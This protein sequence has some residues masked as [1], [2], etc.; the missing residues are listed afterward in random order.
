MTVASLPRRG[1]SALIG[2]TAVVTGV[3]V[4]VPPTSMTSTAAGAP[5]ARLAAAACHRAAPS[6]PVTATP[7]PG[8]P[9]DWVV[10]SFDGT[11]IRAHW[12]PVDLP[13]GQPAPTVLMGPGWGS[14]G[15]TDTS[16]SS[17]QGLLGAMS[18]ATL[19]GA[20]FNVLT[21]DP[22]GFG[23]SGGLAE[24]DSP[25]YEARDVSA[26]IDWAATLPGVEL[27]APGDPRLG[28]VGGSYGG[29]IQFVTAATDCRV[30][31]IVP[32]IA[33]HSLV[34]SLGKS[35]LYKAGWA[36]LLY[37]AATS[38]H[39]DPEI[40]DARAVADV[41]GA[42][43]AAARDWF[44]A[45]GP[46]ALIAR[47]RVPTLIVQGTVDTLFTLQEG[48]TNEQILER[49]HV[50]TAMVWFCGGHGL[51]L[52][53]HGDLSQTTAATLAWLDRYLKGDRAVDTGPGFR[54]VDQNGT[55]HSAPAYPPRAGRPLT[56]D[57]GGTLALDAS[58]VSGPA[59]AT[60]G[61]QPLGGLVGAITPGPATQAVDVPVGVGGRDAVIVGAPVL[62][63]HYRGTTPPGVRPTFV[64]AQ[65]VD[66]T[67]GL[68]LG[69]Q[70]TPVPVT[71][72]GRAHDVTMPLEM[73]AYS[74]TPQSRLELQIVART[75]GYAEPR[76]GGTVDLLHIHLVLPVAAGLTSH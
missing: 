14:A 29:G 75:V 67:S 3:V 31:A 6:H 26:L 49:D 24:V 13:G 62:S 22:R 5:R 12:F 20:G 51:C 60:A 64:F 38:A 46:G 44:A 9:S 28:M 48:A 4:L 18:I 54:F 76:L 1:R 57:G 40:G 11:P 32:T 55:E 68:V 58:S 2:L 45:R 65:L 35:G 33:W 8:V 74:A 7:V 21:W 50:P 42:V 25:L 43:P 15:D 56:A 10:T 59:P 37:A 39:L 30:D 73:A 17:G 61:G 27:D 72:D 34:T 16:P 36:G 41:T 53:P 19:R 63:L 69:N 23:R 52:T 71:L 47:V 66:E 70:I